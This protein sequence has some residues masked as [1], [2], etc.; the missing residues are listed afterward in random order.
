MS[1]DTILSCDACV[2]ETFRVTSANGKI[3]I[4]CED[5][6]CSLLTFPISA[7]DR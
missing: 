4:E 5:C 1:G 2:G 3:Y 6:G 7:A